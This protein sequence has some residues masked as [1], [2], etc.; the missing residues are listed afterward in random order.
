MDSTA[1][2]RRR[3]LIL[4]V[5]IISLTAIVLDNTGLGASQSQL[6]WAINFVGAMHLTALISVLIAV[7][8]AV[9]VWIWMPG[10]ATAGR[11][12]ESGLAGS[13]AV[14]SVPALEA[15]DGI[16]ATGAADA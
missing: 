9:T 11:V 12:V 13:A 16:T 8:G 10:R 5:L 3:W 6:E 14:Q 4:S 2:F 15:K 7:A 1:V